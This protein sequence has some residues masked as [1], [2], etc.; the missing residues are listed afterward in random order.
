MQTKRNIQLEDDVF[1]LSSDPSRFE[2]IA[3]KVFQFQVTHNLVY[4]E[5][6]EIQGR[7][8]P[9]S[10]KEIPFM[11]ISFFK[12]KSII[13]AGLV[14]Q[15][16][17]LSSGTSGLERSKHLVAFTDVYRRSFLQAYSEL[18]GNPEEQVIIALLPNYL[19]QGN[20]SLVFMV[21]ELIA[22]SKQKESGFYLNELTVLVELI[23]S[24]QSTN[25]KIILFGVAYALL[26]LAVLKPDLSG[27][28]IIETGGMKGRR[29]ELLKEELHHVLSSQMNHPV[30]N[31]EYGMTEMLSQAY[32]KEE[33]WF[34]S[35]K[36]LKI[37]IREVNDPLSYVKDGK[38]GG[39]NVIDLANIYSCS[40]F[41]TDDLG[42]CKG[43]FFK[44]LGRFDNSDIRGCNLLV[45]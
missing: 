28:T 39:V 7:T 27:V 18:I 34:H 13:S 36:W 9:K 10:L 41:A 12:T 3:L 25:R 32:S 19:E 16:L 31:S 44:I 26:D 6:C 11:P 21:S 45:N 24:I 2:E 37:L 29:K 22:R 20:S 4:K 33:Q 42:V 5:F 43:D 14:E 38:T 30:I 35:P 17:F 1:R 15:E 40:F 8:T 23:Q